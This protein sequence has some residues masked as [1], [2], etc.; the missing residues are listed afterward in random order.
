MTLRHS[1]CFSGGYSF[2]PVAT[3]VPPSQHHR[4]IWLYFSRHK[5]SAGSNN[6]IFFHVNHH[7]ILWVKLQ[8][9]I[10]SLQQNFCSSFA[11]VVVNVRNSKVAIKFHFHFPIPMHFTS[12]Y[13]TLHTI[14]YYFLLSK[15]R[16]RLFGFSTTSFPF[17]FL[18]ILLLFLLYTQTQ[19]LSQKYT[20]W[21]AFK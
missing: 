20:Q 8:M 3:Y 11:F 7:E 12:Q 2:C 14:L 10:S 4:H 16:E 5:N 13:C 9:H 15:K 21:D 6:E 17:H 19:L 1:W 18:N